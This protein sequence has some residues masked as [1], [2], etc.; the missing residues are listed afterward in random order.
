MGNENDLLGSCS[1]GG[2]S[3]SPL[4]EC[5]DGGRGPKGPHLDHR[6]VIPFSYFWLWNRYPN[7]QNNQ[8]NKINQINQINQKRDN[9]INQILLVNL[10]T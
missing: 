3:A 8:N 7:N 10:V 4:Q 5:G 1:Q 2:R 6:L 9:Q